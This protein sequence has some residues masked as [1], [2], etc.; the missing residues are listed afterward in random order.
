MNLRQ[1]N[2][3]RADRQRNPAALQRFKHLRAAPG[4]E[5][6]GQPVGIESRSRPTDPDP[7]LHHPVEILADAA[8]RLLAVRRD[9]YGG[10]KL[11]MPGDSFQQKAVMKIGRGGEAVLMPDDRPGD[12][13]PRHV[14]QQQSNRSPAGNF[15]V[16]G[17]KTDRRGNVR[18]GKRPFPVRIVKMTSSPNIIL[19]EQNKTGKR[20]FRQFFFT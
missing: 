8:L 14:R 12:I 7:R 20:R 6:V 19:S 9:E 15:G 18:H 2:L 11:R 5:K 4:V 1:G 16:T 10:I 13:Q 17:E 3:F